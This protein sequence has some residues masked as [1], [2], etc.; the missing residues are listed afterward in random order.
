MINTKDPGVNYVPA[1]LVLG[2]VGLESPPLVIFIIPNTQPLYIHNPLPVLV[3]PLSPPPLFFFFKFDVHLPFHFFAFLSL[4]LLFHYTPL[5]H[6]LLP[7]IRKHL[8]QGLAASPLQIIDFARS[9]AACLCAPVPRVGGPSDAQTLP[10][11]S[12]VR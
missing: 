2:C 3:L 4:L 12:I 5:K 6:I 11:A 7:I 1:W 9:S 8:T 10:V